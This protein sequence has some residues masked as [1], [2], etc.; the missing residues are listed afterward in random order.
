MLHEFAHV[1]LGEG[2]ICDIDD[3]SPR[4][5]SEWQVERFCN[6]VAAAVSMPKDRFLGHKTIVRHEPG[7][8]EWSNTEIAY[9][10]RTFGVSREATV[11]R[12]ET[13]RLTTMAFYLSKRWQ[14]HEE[15]R[16]KQR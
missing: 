8:T 5:E 1:L 16:T 13:F 6:R 14:Y 15:V 7:L 4:E 10:A 2:A 11:R 3:F 9:L 12:L